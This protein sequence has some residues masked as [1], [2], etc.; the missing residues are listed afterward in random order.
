MTI[1]E[2]RPNGTALVRGEKVM[3][4]S[5]GEEWVQLSGIIRLSDIDADNRI[6]SIRVADAQIAYSG[7][8]AVQ[9][10]G[11]PGWLSRFFSIVSPF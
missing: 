11:K 5:Q 7:K 6:A 4:F 2:V 3:N 10:A 9:R 8:G 1:A